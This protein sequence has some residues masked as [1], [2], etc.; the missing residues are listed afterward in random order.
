MLGLITASFTT[1]LT[2]N[3]DATSFLWLL[4]L[5]AAVATV[6]KALK[7]RDVSTADFIRE[8]VVLFG[9]IILF[10]IGVAIILYAVTRLLTE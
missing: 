6:Y 10:M 1:P 9:T 7:V 5:V 3:N 2:I 8:T 4:P